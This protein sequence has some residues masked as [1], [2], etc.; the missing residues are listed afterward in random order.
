MAPAQGPRGATEGRRLKWRVG[1]T[2]F[3]LMILIYWGIGLQFSFAYTLQNQAQADA[4]IFSYLW[5]LPAIGVPLAVIIPLL[6]LRPIVRDYE[7]MLRGEALADPAASAARL[8][9]Y[10]HR[11]VWYFT[12]ASI[13]AY[14]VGTLLNWYTAHSPIDEVL[15]AVPLGLPLG[16]L[17]SLASYLALVHYLE[18]VRRLFVLR[19]GYAPAPK[20]LT[21]I[22]RKVVIT[23]ITIVGLSLALLWLIAYAKG[24]LLLEDQLQAR[25]GETT[26]PA[27]VEAAL[28]LG[29]RDFQ[30]RLDA[31]K[32]G[33]RGYT[34]LVDAGGTLL[35]DHPRDA[36]TLADEG[37]GPVERGAI[38]G[39]GQGRFIDRV[40]VVR[41]VAFTQVPGTSDHVVVVT[42]RDDFAGQLNDM[43]SAMLAVTALGLGLAATLTLTGARAITRPIRELTEAM[44]RARDDGTGGQANL[45][46]DD[47]VGALAGSYAHMMGRLREKTQALEES[48]VRLKEMDAVKN[49]FINIASHELR[50]PMTPIRTELHI[51]QA[52][53]RGPLTEEQRR[54]LQ[55]IGRNVDRLNR[56]IRDL[57]EASRMQAGQLRLVPRRVRL[58]E[59]VAAV[60]GTMQGEARHKAVTLEATLDVAPDLDLMVD[61]DRVTQVLMNLVENAIQFTPAQGH[62]TIRARHDGELVRLSVHDTG[63]GIDPAVVPRLFQ[64]FSQAE[65]GVPRTEGGTGLGLFICKGIV[66]G[67]GGRIWCESEG[68][69]RGTTMLFT[70]PPAPPMEPEEPAPEPAA[71]P[72]ARADPRRP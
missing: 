63:A 28:H 61:E 46:T 24:Q 55:M 18:P 58:T 62:V 23:S 29:E 6:L 47:E 3:A 17:F 34:F 69:G 56:L 19:H 45:V 15:K 50:T 10:P 13:G 35:S 72:A 64:P 60:V 67:H 33:A 48:V 49:R 38:V 37:W 51:I 2:L 20:P 52:G 42:Y 53:K 41:L 1:V 68:K 43:T 66:E 65:P 8:L 27:A 40:D 57:L 16:L 44:R 59:M 32:L 21:S 4:T 11:I 71:A 12:P 14:M 25:M 31:V 70:L 22:Y 7:A 39:G 9:R 30:A 54:G 36:A 5:E 26:L